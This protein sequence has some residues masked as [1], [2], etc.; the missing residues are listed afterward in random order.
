MDRTRHDDEDPLLAEQIAY[1]RAV[2]REYE[3]HAIPETSPDELCAA[4]EELGPTGHV[5]ELACGPGMWTERLLRHAASVTAV[6]ASPE[7]LERA[8]ARVGGDRVRFVRADLFRWAPDRRYDTVFFGFWLSHVP[9]ERFEAFWSTVADCLEPK[10]RV[11]FVDDAHRT[12][13][14]LIEG[15]G[16]STIER[17]LN[18][19]TAFRAVKVPHR[20]EDLER[21]LEALG[22][23]IRVRATASG[24]FY[25]GTGARG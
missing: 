2:A 22:W 6:D 23:D 21:R 18:D 7:M 14:E 20:P 25:W 4:L 13:D 9:L 3:D 12:P 19:G 5:L 11:F 24:P 1:Y 16:S 17:R 15:E 8:S 10:G